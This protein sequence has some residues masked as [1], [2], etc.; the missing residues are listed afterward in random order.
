MNLEC[1]AVG[2]GINV[3]LRDL[4]MVAQRLETS[5]VPEFPASHTRRYPIYW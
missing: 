3:E 2:G 1:G 5:Y 4:N